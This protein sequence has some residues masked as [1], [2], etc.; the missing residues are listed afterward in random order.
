ML[1]L[2]DA[3]VDSLKI[4]GRM[5]SAYYAAIVTRAYRKAIDA[6]AGAKAD[7]ATESAGITSGRG[8]ISRTELKH[9]RD[10]I[11]KVSHRQF[12]TG[13]YFDDP[14]AVEPNLAEYARDYL[15]LG[16]V[17]DE[18]EPGLYALD[19][20]N[21]ISSGERIEYIGPDVLYLQDMDF[22]LLDGAGSPLQKA[23]HGKENYLKT[24]L[25]VKPGYLIRKRLR[26]A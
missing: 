13:F 18:I 25:P 15:F 12:S 14:A 16:T 26:Q 4:E 6:A 10:E 22:E 17:L 7:G 21:T 9:Y 5:K 20:K 24:G 1:Q 8:E 2:I 3:G 19:V 11:F 23:D